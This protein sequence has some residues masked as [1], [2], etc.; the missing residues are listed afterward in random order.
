[1]GSLDFARALI[2]YR[3]GARRAIFCICRFVFCIVGSCVGSFSLVLGP[4]MGPWVLRV[5]GADC[6][7]I[8][9]SNKVK[10]KRKTK[11]RTQT[12]PIAVFAALT[13]RSCFP[14]WVLHPPSH[15]PTHP[16]PRTPHPA[17]RTPHHTHEPT[18][19]PPPTHTTRKREVLSRHTAVIYI[20]KSEVHAP[21][22]TPRPFFAFFSLD[23]S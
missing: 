5:R 12:R 4:G 16:T 2:L 1:M 7:V 22:S 23:L 9:G 15:N 6:L 14:L 20:R 21:L 19:C 10:S 13:S 18:P 17:P 11:P 3:R 8:Q